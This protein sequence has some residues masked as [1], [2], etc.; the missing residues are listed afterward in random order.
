VNFEL[1]LKA[2]TTPGSNSGVYVHTKYQED[3]WP[4]AGYECQVNSTQKDPKKTG[5]LYGIINIVVDPPDGSGTEKFEPYVMYDQKG[6]NLRMPSAPSRDGEWFDY[7]IT[8]MGKTITIRVNGQITVQFTE[9]D[10]WAGAGPGG[11]GRRLSKGTIALQAHDP[12]STVYYKD[13]RIKPL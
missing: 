3:G 9:P 10:G 1:K 5:S 7:H 8:V 4:D 6:V 11:A 2:K 13:L 12:G